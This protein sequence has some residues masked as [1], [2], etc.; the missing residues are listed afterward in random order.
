MRLLLPTVA[1]LLAM[2]SMPASAQTLEQM[3]GQMILVGFSGDSSSDASVVAVTEQVARSEIGGVMYLR[4]NVAS[5][6][7]VQA[8]NRA[9]LAA[10]PSLPPFISLD[11]EGGSVE[12]LTRS[13]GFAEIPSAAAIASTR[14]VS[15]ARILFNAQA[16]AI[17]EWGFNVNFAP[18]T[19]LSTNPANQVIAKFGRAFSDGPNTVTAYAEQVIAAHHQSGVLT[20]LKHFPGHGSSAGDTHEGYVDIT[21]SWNDSELAPYRALITQ[22][23]ADF[24]MIGHLVHQGYSP[25]P[26]S[27]AP[28]W[29]TGVLRDELGFEGVVISDDL[30]M[31]AIREHYGLRETVRRAVMAGMDVL[32]FSNTA[33]PRATLS[34]EL[35]TILVEEANADPAFRA[36]IEESYR[37][38]V[39]LKARIGQRQ[40]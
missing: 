40:G 30:E 15:E 7:A 12:R 14:S 34:G 6:D 21:D 18:V 4:T 9:F 11:Q 33:R 1:A 39:A 24:V 27:L 26:A 29:I 2:A 38:I 19:D 22:S 10:S 3:A 36:R 28:E 17:A 20:A 25:L 35:R 16:Q 8:M 31:G 5:R 32:L 23:Y 37:R 13:V